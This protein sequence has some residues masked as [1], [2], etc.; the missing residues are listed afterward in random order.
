MIDTKKRLKLLLLSRKK[1]LFIKGKKIR[2]KEISSKIGTLNNNF[3]FR[4]LKFNEEGV[5]LRLQKIPYEV[6]PK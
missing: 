1:K 5:F 4:F 2:E 6:I 3:S